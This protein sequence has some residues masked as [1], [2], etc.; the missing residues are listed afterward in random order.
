M[1]VPLQV[2]AENR[3]CK[4]GIWR[5][6]K[7]TANA[8]FYP[9]SGTASAGSCKTLIDYFLTMITEQDLTLLRESIY[10]IPELN[11]CRI[12]LYGNNQCRVIREGVI[13]SVNYE[14]VVIIEEITDLIQAPVTT[15]RPI[16]PPRAEPA[17]THVLNRSQAVP[18]LIGAGL[19]CGLAVWSGVEIIGGTIGAPATGGTS[20][21][22]TV[23]GW[24]GFAMS[25]IQCING[26]TRSYQ[27][28]FHP[29]ED[30]LH[31]WDQNDWY[32]W[33][34]FAVDAIDV[35]TGVAGVTLLGRRLARLL[36]ERRALITVVPEG[37]QGLDRMSRDERKRAVQQAIQD[38]A[39]DPAAQRELEAVLR[40]GGQLTEQQIRNIINY[41]T[42]TVRQGRMVQGA[43]TTVVANRLEE[44][45]T[46][47][48]A[49]RA[50]RADLNTER[51]MAVASIALSATPQEW[52][53]S[54]SGS[55]NTTVGWV[56]NIFKN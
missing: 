5:I 14:K 32:R 49:A 53:G 36:A 43:I 29:D 13:P 18:E 35:G 38:L 46:R 30:T 19:S 33:S 55:V 22:I 37:L 3:S 45:I 15:A 44:Q 51:R 27:V 7:L 39:R 40:E 52:T 56:I 10:A 21:V 6:Y 23:I 34:M 20:L 2:R 4:Y 12:G 24:T 17:T 31:Q 54:G 42:A 48:I 47:A 26:L 16:S 41:G 9:K 28:A 11:G 1:L 8:L 50:A 25:S